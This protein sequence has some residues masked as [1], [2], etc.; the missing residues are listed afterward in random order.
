MT[1]PVLD[2]EEWF[3]VQHPGGDYLRAYVID[4]HG[5]EVGQVYADLLAGNP[6]EV[7]ADAPISAFSA[8]ELT[9][10]LVEAAA[11]VEGGPA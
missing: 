10:R 1:A 9:L 2:R 11:F 8:R 7:H 3:V 5:D 6:I 4:E